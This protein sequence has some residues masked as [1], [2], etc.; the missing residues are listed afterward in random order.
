M[1]TI[2]TFARGARGLRVMWLCEEMGL[3]YQVVVVPAPADE[4]YRALNPLGSVPFLTDDNGVAINE[5]VAMLLYIAQR[6]GPT[7]LLPANDDPLLARVLQMAV[8]SEASLGGLN[9]LIETLFTAP[10]QDKRNFTVLAIERRLEGALAYLE[11]LLGA[12]P[13]LCGERFTV[14]D[15]AISTSLGMWR[16]A[17]GKSLSEPLAAYQGRLAE[18]PAQIRARDKQKRLTAA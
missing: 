16:G 9:P 3:P 17:L 1:L 18:R 4:T 5:S 11:Q 7:P 13:F 14:A 10:E 2:H 15:I 8:Y 6:Q 12:G